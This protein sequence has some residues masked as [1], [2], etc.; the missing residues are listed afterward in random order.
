MD[1]FHPNKN[2]MSKISVI[3]PTYNCARYITQAIDSVLKQTYNDFEIIIIDDGSTDNTREAIERY[4]V[5]KN[6]RCFHQKNLGLAASR[7]KGI[8]I[9][10][11]EYIALLDADDYWT[12]NKLEIQLKAFE[13][14]QNIELVHSNVYVIYEEDKT[15]VEKYCLNINYNSLTQRQ[16]FEKILFWEADICIPSTLI[17]RT[18]FDKVGNF[19]EKLSHLGCE[20]REF[21][22]RAFR[23]CKSFFINEYLYYYLVRKNSMTKNRER[24][25]QARV[26]V[27]E[28]TI[29]ETEYFKNKKR[30][31]QMVYSKLYL[32][33][34]LNF[35]RAEDKRSA[36]IYL[37][38][39]LYFDCLSLKALI[40]FILCLSP[41]KFIKFLRNLKNINL[42]DA[43]FTKEI[44]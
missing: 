28:K 1:N 6:I 7:N 31:K 25:Q 32:S 41:N 10:S 37:F 36:K 19:D 38:K 16:I 20:D 3:I 29:Q 34:G 35:F 23:K 12:S 24:M 15:K 22:L 14:N 33:E 44:I 39:S 26:Y 40:F 42:N 30:A 8:Q 17:K 18:V 4:L 5:Y 9:A 2:I 21:C 43:S 27:V 13:R 11:G